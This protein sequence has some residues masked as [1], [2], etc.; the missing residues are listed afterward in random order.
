MKSE[1]IAGARDK[2]HARAIRQGRESRWLV[3]HGYDGLWNADGQCACEADDLYPCGER[4]A[5]R[6]GYK[7]TCTEACEH[8][9]LGPLA[10]NWHITGLAPVTRSQGK[11]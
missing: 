11:G 5:C 4:G 2:G 1:P 10:L 6:P 3:A 7:E 9:M 8:E